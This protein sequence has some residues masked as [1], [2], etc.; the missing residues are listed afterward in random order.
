M[1]GKF[2]SL[3]RRDA[4]EW[5]R[6]KHELAD[7]SQDL[8]ETGPVRAEYWQSMRD[9]ENMKEF[10]RKEKYTEPEIEMIHNGVIARNDGLMRKYMTRLR[11]RQDKD[12]KNLPIIW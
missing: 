4:F 1:F 2:H 5:W 9:I 8:H 6:R 12:R 10:L 3:R 7:L 11:I